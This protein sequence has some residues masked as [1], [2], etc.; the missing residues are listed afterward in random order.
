MQDQQ[1]LNAHPGHLIE[2]PDVDQRNEEKRKKS[3]TWVLRMSCLQEGHRMCSCSDVHCV[4]LW[5]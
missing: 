2:Q 5:T 1:D 3:L 4:Y